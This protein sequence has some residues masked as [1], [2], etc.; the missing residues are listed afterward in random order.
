VRRGMPFCLWDSCGEPR[1]SPDLWDFCGA[2]GRPAHSLQ[3]IGHRRTH[4]RGCVG[5]RRGRTGSVVD[6]YDDAA[7]AHLLLV[8]SR[9]P[10]AC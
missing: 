5:T 1:R 2:S 6:D 10:I 4:D 8:I 7:G 3:L 9:V